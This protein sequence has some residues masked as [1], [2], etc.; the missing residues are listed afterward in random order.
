MCMECVYL[1]VCVILCQHVLCIG[2][3]VCCIC[4]VWVCMDTWYIY[5]ICVDAGMC[6][7]CRFSCVTSIA[8]VYTCSCV[9]YMH[10]FMFCVGDICEHV[11]VCLVYVHMFISVHMSRDQRLTSGVVLG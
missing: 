8:G 10:M 3:N 4:V 6:G 11:H 2:V 1:C 7:M 5:D 9:W